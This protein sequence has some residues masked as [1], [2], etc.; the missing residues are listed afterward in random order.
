VISPVIVVPSVKAYGWGRPGDDAP[1]REV[2][3][4]GVALLTSYDRDAHAAGYVVTTEGDPWEELPRINKEGLS[5]LRDDGH[6]VKVT[7]LF[8]DLDLHNPD[9]D[10]DFPE[11]VIAEWAVGQVAAIES[12]AFFDSNPCGR[13]RTKNGIRLYWPLDPWI[14]PEEH[15]ELLPQLL[16]EIQRT[17]DGVLSPDRK[18]MG[19]NRVFRLPCVVRAGVRESRDVVFG[20]PL[21][22][23][24]AELAKPSKFKGIEKASA[25]LMPGKKLKKGKRNDGLFRIA[26]SLRRSLSDPDALLQALLIENDKVCD[27]PMEEDEVRKIVFSAARYEPEE[28]PLETDEGLVLGSANEVGDHVLRRMES[29]EGPKYVY[30]R[31]S[32]WSYSTDTGV[33][34]DVPRY[35]LWRNIMAMD[36]VAIRAKRLTH[37]K[38]GADTCKSVERLIAMKRARPGFFD[39]EGGGVCFSN[40]LVSVESGQVDLLPFDHQARKRAALSWDY[41]E[42]PLFPRFKRFLDGCFKDADDAEDRIQ[43]LRE[44]I[45]A[46]LCGLATTYA[47]ALLLVGEGLNGKSTFLNI[48]SALFPS[49]SRVSVSPHMMGNE[50]QRAKLA[51]AKINIVQELPRSD[52]SASAT[53]KAI[54]SGEETGARQI[55]QEPYY[56]RPIAAHLFACNSL[57]EV[58]D[59]SVG[60]RRR[61]QICAFDRHIPL[62]E[63]D[64]NIERDVIRHELGAVASWAVAGVPGLMKRKDYHTPKSS[65]RLT[66]EWRIDSDHIAEFVRDATDYHTPESSEH[67]RGQTGAS[68]LYALYCSWAARMGYQQVSV[69][70]REFSKRLRSQGVQRKRIAGG[71]VY[72]VGVA[73]ARQA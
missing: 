53:F 49:E 36:G 64:L 59:L 8:V 51:G 7:V 20:S 56:Y 45:G 32:L 13:Y 71:F 69:S 12:S 37:L 26:C 73:K 63:K 17:T 11:S 61:W 60:F 57:P 33:W 19:W 40:A 47:K 35:A 44:F 15:E 42:M 55:R 48:V 9:D 46:S 50:Y 18:A 58:S 52:V 41:E 5:S 62:D 4:L 3:E 21:L 54:V 28:S 10:E 22:W 6:D 72:K 1:P 24:P 29:P 30:D 31:G 2:V 70:S 43:L 67:R 25:S 38:V 16:T 34:V 39:E 14:S 68:R 23:R 27:P 65:V 66:D